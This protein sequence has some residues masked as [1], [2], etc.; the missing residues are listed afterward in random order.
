M[1]AIFKSKLSVLQAE[2]GTLQIGRVDKIRLFPYQ[3]LT[4]KK[5]YQVN[6]LENSSHK[7]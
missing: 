6:T 5:L 4:A 1:K 2:I 3:I 7:K